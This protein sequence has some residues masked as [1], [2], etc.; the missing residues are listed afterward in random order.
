MFIIVRR[1]GHASPGCLFYTN[2][3]WTPLEIKLVKFKAWVLLETWKWRSFELLSKW[4]EFKK[5]LAN[6]NVYFGIFG[7]FPTKKIVMKEL[8]GA[9]LWLFG[10]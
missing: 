2:A 1:S 10:D 4:F 6:F 9:F 5:G 3:H 7:L 8:K